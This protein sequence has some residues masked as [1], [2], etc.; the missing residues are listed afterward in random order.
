MK[1]FAFLVIAALAPLSM[2]PAEERPA[3]KGNAG[4]QIKVEARVQAPEIMAIRIHHDMCPFCKKLKPEF[5]RL[6]AKVMDASVLFLTL[7]LST[8][9][10]Q[11]QAALMVGALGLQ[12][13]WTGDFSRIGTVTFLD[14]KSKKTLVEF[15][16]DGQESLDKAL[17]IAV[18]M[19]RK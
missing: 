18:Q 7:D 4:S 12:N 10:T 1:R 9:A 16:A 5:E 8:P 6:N 19:Q 2:A 15:R 17:G 14:A 3:S 13:I 11:Q